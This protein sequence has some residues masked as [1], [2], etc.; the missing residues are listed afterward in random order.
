MTESAAKQGALQLLHALLKSFDVHHFSAEFDVRLFVVA[1]ERELS[2]L[3]P[4]ASLRACIWKTLGL[5]VGKFG[6]GL[7]EETAGL[8]AR[9][10]RS[11]SA[12]FRSPKPEIVALVGYLK[13]LRRF[14]RLLILSDDER[15]LTRKGFAR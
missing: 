4:T 10:L 8:G 13:A 3:H 6:T 15:K 5:L 14:L 11:I 12:E 9:L 1:L 2:L 7:E